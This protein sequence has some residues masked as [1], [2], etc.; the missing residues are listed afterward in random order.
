MDGLIMDRPLLMKQLLW[1]AERVFGDKRI[2]SRTGDGEDL[3]YTYAEYAVRARKLAQALTALG[4]Q[5][6]RVCG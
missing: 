3:S 5:P 1:R 4:V 2:I 6:I